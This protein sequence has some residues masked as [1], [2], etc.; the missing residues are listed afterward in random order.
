MKQ[1]FFLIV[2]LPLSVF[3][4]TSIV[5]DKSGETSL[6]FSN[7]KTVLFNSGD[8]SIGA[9]F[10]FSNV[11]P[12]KN[13]GL[14]TFWGWAVKLKSNDGISTLLD[15][16]DFMPRFTLG[17]FKG[18][19]MKSSSKS[20]SNSIYY[21]TD[22]GNSVF[23]LLSQQTLNKLE[24]TSF[25]N[26]RIKLGFNRLGAWGKSTTLFGISSEFGS[27]NNLDDLTA[28]ERYKSSIDNSSTPSTIVVSNKKS[29][30]SG[31]YKEGNM[32]KINMDYLVFPTCLKGRVGLG[33]YFRGGLGGDFSRQNLGVGCFLGKEGA[34]DKIVLGLVYQINDVFNQLKEEPSFQKR[35]GISITAGYSF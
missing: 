12:K 22:I 1:I 9:G 24:K 26:W 11:T 16:Y 2:I 7:N 29:G 19:A 34:P 18:R 5:Q 15:G 23:N 31:D 6:N 35:T 25:F 27:Y 17:V 8:A 20:S 21:G 30:F 32:L 4:Q 14:E 10:S 13:N 33:G 28:V 3:S